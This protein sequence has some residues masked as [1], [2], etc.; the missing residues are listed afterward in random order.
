MRKEIIILILL[1]ACTHREFNN[2]YDPA[3]YP[4]APVLLSPGGMVRENPPEFRWEVEEPPASYLFIISPCPDFSDTLYKRV[5]NDTSLS[6][7]L[8]PDISL[9]SSDTFWWKVCARNSSKMGNGSDTFFVLNHILY[10]YGISFEGF[11]EDEEG[12][13]Y[14]WKTERDKINLYRLGEEYSPQWIMTLGSFSGEVL[15]IPDTFCFTYDLDS[16]VVRH[17]LSL[18]S[19]IL[20]KDT[21]SF[22]FSILHSFPLSS[23]HLAVYYYDTLWIPHGLMYYDTICLYE[24]PTSGILERGWV[25]DNIFLELKGGVLRGYKM[26]DSLLFLYRFDNVCH[27]LT[28][29][30]RFAVKDGL[31]I[32]IYSL[33]NPESPELEDI[34]V[35]EELPGKTRF[36]GRFLGINTGDYLHIYDMEGDSLIARKKGGE[37]PWYTVKREEG[38]FLPSYYLYFPSL[39][40]R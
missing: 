1:T 20:T 3:N 28:N 24:L 33:E 9:C 10:P 11:M 34:I 4:P 22:P 15:Y 21:L 19:L 8:I 2:P 40:A 31:I 39:H 29:E 13:V 26:E 16:A 14:G 27:L 25:L 35:C 6:Q 7:T 12:A 23:H 30:R 36:S 17:I 5:I 38:I 32:R 18:S 37:I